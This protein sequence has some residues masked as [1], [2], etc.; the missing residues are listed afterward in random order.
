MTKA[1]ELQRIASGLYRVEDLVA[2]LDQ[3]E[4]GLKVQEKSLRSELV[5]WMK[6]NEE[7]GVTWAD[8]SY[9]LDGKWGLMV[10]KE[11]K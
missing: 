7:S 9:E 1:K 8:R 2:L 4:Y 10:H 6:D 11:K 3:L 5:Q